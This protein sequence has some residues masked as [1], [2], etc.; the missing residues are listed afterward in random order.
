MSETSIVCSTLSFS[1]PGE[2]PL[3][4]QLSFA[5]GSGHTGLV[6][7][8]GAGKSTLLKLIVGEYRPTGGSVTVDGVIGYLP[9]TLPFDGRRT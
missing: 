3:F 9:Q 5:V 8:N 1:W 2:T 6:A 7:P 4:E